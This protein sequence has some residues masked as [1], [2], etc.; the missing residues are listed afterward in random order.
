MF[1]T[2]FISVTHDDDDDV[3]V[4]LLLAAHPFLKRVED[5]LVKWHEK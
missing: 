5:K 4:N 3:H 2:R 1:P